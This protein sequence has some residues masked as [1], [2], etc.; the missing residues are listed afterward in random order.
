MIL[1]YVIGIGFGANTERLKKSLEEFGLF[2]YASAKEQTLFEANWNI[3]N[4]R[5]LMRLGKLNASKV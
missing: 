5:K 3:H 1:S 4:K 2:K